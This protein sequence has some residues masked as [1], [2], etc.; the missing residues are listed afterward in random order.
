MRNMNG[1]WLVGLVFFLCLAPASFAL[2]NQGDLRRGI[3]MRPKNFQPL[4]VPEGGSSLIYVLGAGL[5]CLGGMLVR[6]NA[7]QS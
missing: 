3:P 2:P 4:T 6:T 7:R 1:K 5:I